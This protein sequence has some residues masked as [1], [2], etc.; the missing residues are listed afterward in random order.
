MPVEVSL[1]TPL[2]DALNAAILPKLVEVGWG[3]GGSDDSTLA[4]YVI[5]MLVNGKSQDQ[6]AAE[7]SNELLSLSP[8]DPSAR[9]FCAW[10]F[11][12]IEVLNAQLNG[13]QAGDG[14]NAMEST[15]M[16]T[17]MTPNDVAE[18]NA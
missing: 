15:D 1:N 6:I 8:D 11:N 17:D 5:L 12:Q 14:G 18:L 3:S 4:E 2:A 16:D 9:E 13:G 10:L 7:L